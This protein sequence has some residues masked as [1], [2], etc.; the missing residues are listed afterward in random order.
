MYFAV[1]VMCTGGVGSTG[2][3]AEVAVPVVCSFSQWESDVCGC[4]VERTYV[5]LDKFNCLYTCVLSSLE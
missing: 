3:D 2:G 4:Q 5:R 1:K